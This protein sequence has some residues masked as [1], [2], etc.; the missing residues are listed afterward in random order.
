MVVELLRMTILLLPFVLIAVAIRRQ[1]GWTAALA[2]GLVVVLFGAWFAPAFGTVGAVVLAAVTV[3][4]VIGRR[5]KL[6]ETAGAA[7]VWCA[8]YSLLVLPPW[9][10]VPFPEGLTEGGETYPPRGAWWISL[11]LV[12]VVLAAVLTAIRR[13][14]SS[15]RRETG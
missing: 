11:L 10:Y 5:L 2:V 7:V 9:F 6:H 8:A 13:L 12:L 1:S 14:R 3:A 4:S 15:T